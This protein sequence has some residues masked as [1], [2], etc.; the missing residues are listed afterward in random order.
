MKMFLITYRGKPMLGS[1]EAQKFGGGYI[2]YYI[3]ERKFEKA[4]KIARREIEINNW[5]VITLEEVVKV[6]KRSYSLDDPNLQYYEQAL[7]DNTVFVFHT[8]PKQDKTKIQA[9]R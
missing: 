4:D 9:K 3:K 8:Y 5:K 7:I 1:K 6:N 2:N